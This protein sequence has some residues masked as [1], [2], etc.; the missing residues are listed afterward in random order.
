MAI[1]HHFI[2]FQ[3]EISC[4]RCNGER[5]LDAIH[6]VLHRFMFLKLDFKEVFGEGRNEAFHLR[7]RKL[8]PKVSE[9]D[10]SFLFQRGNKTRA[11]HCSFKL[12][13]EFIPPRVIFL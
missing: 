1:R 9:E 8:S 3:K 10:I 2:F 4:W 5:R 7:K 11:Y 6:I 13:N 12:A